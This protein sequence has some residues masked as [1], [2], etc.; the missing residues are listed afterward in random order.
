MRNLVVALM[1]MEN[2]FSMDYVKLGKSSLSVS[3]VCFGSMTWGQQNTED[4]GIEQLN[5]AFSEYGVNFIDTAE[6][7]P[8]PNK[9]ETQGATDRVIGKWLKT[10]DRSKVI[11]ATKVSGASDR[12]TYMP[13]RVG[14]GTRVRK[15]DI[16]SSIDASL[17][18]LGTSYV[19]LLQ[20]HW[21]DRYVPLFGASPYDYNLERDYISFQEQLEA[22]NELVQAGKVRHIGLS[23][24]TPYGVMKFSQLSEQLK[25]PNFISIQNS[26]SLVVRSDFE[27]GLKEVCSPRHENVGLL[28]YSPLAGGVLTGKYLRDDVALTWR[29]NLFEGYMARYKQSLCQKAVIKYCEIAKKYDMTPTELALAWCYT[30]PHVASTIIGATSVQQ[31]KENLNAYKLCSKITPEVVQEIDDVYKVY[32]DPSKI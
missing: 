9:A 17:N 8:I 15:S 23:N 29:L 26:Y 16:F 19:D 2:V 7:Y 27:N 32:R 20:I 13:G 5:V 6:M 22:L 1:L 30:R 12:L 11:L 18:R 3:K 25:L 31:L 21:P 14:T 28:A 10:V 24:E 4:E